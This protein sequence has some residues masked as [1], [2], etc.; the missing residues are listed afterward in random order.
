LVNEGLTVYAG[1]P[2]SFDDVCGTLKTRI[3][4]ILLLGSLVMAAVIMMFNQLL[5]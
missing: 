4:S 3:Q 5:L 1:S 2:S